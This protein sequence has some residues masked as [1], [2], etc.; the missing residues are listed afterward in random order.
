RDWPAV[1][2]ALPSVEGRIILDLGCAIGDLAAEFVTR[3]A[4]VIGVDLNEELLCEARSR[5]LS[6]AE[7]RTHDL[8]ALPDL[9]VEADAVWTSFVAAYFPDLPSS[10][11]AWMRNL[12][13]G[14]WIALTEIDDMF[15]HEPLGVRTKASLSAFVEDALATGRYDFRMGR[16]LGGFLERCGF[17]V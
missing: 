2:R 15:G 14:G 9:G 3:G 10:L 4:H 12:K 16:K 6:G 7:F 13:A 8:R 5:R 1:F 17:A 11:V